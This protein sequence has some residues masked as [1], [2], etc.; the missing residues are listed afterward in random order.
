LNFESIS[1][2]QWMQKKGIGFDEFID[3]NC[4]LRARCLRLRRVVGCLPA[5][6][7]VVG[8]Q[9]SVVGISARAL[10][11]RCRTLDR[12]SPAADDHSAARRG[13]ASSM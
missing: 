5:A 6:L 8:A 3:Y 9:W 13:A 12:G 4:A 1:D 7:S 11:A 10:P 2:L